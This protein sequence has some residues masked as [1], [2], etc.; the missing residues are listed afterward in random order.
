MDINSQITLQIMASVF[1][2]FSKFDATPEIVA[3][4]MRIFSSYSIVPSMINSFQ[5]DVQTNT[6]LTKQKPQIVSNKNGFNIDIKDERIDVLLNAPFNSNISNMSIKEKV[7]N[8]FD[9]LRI[10]MEYTGIKSN[11]LAYNEEVILGNFSEDKMK[12]IYNKLFLDNKYYDSN[13]TFDWEFRI[14]KKIS[15]SICNVE[16]SLNIITHLKRN[17]VVINLNGKQNKVDRIGYHFD[18]NTLQDN[19]SARFDEKAIYDFYN[20]I[21]ECREAIERELLTEIS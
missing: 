8:K 13:S 10:V 18:F 2:D 5:V 14:N 21:I 3:D 6:I 12:T 16:E 4:L 15:T 20:K 9:M 1:G 11:R 7:K 19:N 17:L